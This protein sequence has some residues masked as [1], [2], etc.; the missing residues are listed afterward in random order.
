M[1]NAGEVWGGAFWDVRRIL[2]CKDEARGC[3]KADRIVFE[4]V[5]SLNPDPKMAIPFVAR[6]VDNTQRAAGDDEAKQVH[7]AF[8]RRGL[9]SEMAPRRG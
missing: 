7:D 3:Q 1:H 8:A 9:R 4:S 2:G 6:I 5:P